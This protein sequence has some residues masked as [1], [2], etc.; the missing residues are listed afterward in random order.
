MF[1]AITNSFLYIII[2]PEPVSGN[3]I[4]KIKSFFTLLPKQSTPYLTETKVLIVI[5][6]QIKF[7]LIFFPLLLKNVACTFK[8]CSD[9]LRYPLRF[10]SVQIMCR[11]NPRLSRMKSV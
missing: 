4:K 6:N 10:Y 5:K 7:Y 9:S 1:G 2:P 8:D 11:R 3:S